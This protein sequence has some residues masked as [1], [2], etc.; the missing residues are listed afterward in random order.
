RVVQQAVPGLAQ[1]LAFARARGLLPRSGVFK[2]WDSATCQPARPFPPELT[3][4]VRL[5]LLPSAHML[6]LAVRT[7]EWRPDSNPSPN[8]QPAAT[9]QLNSAAVP[10]RAMTSPVAP[11]LDSALLPSGAS[12]SSLP[13]HALATPVVE[14]GPL[15]EQLCMRVA[16]CLAD[17]ARHMLS[18]YDE[19]WVPPTPA[20]AT[21]Q[22]AGRPGSQG[23]V[24]AELE[25]PWRQAARMAVA[26]EQRCL[27]AML[28]R[29]G[30]P[31][32][33][34]KEAARLV[35]ADVLTVWSAPRRGMWGVRR[36]KGQDQG[37]DD[38]S[39]E[40]DSSDRSS[41]EEETSDSSSAE[42]NDDD[43]GKGSRGNNS[44]HAALPRPAPRP[45][46]AFSF[47]FDL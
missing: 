20:V 36:A 35:A 23:D 22:P 26:A 14:V 11:A 29:W 31:T 15:D 19:V 30:G 42:S 7:A 38:S 43:G 34:L 4:L 16:A 9:C 25:P 47:A 24:L 37:S 1:R 10:S 12:C 45:P 40:D 17:L 28:D 3:E 41:D 2:V 33:D 18:R 44:G 6:S 13:V 8:T 46:P 39:G 21:A 32:V 27:V 5:L